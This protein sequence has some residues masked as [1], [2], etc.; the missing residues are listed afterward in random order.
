MA[1]KFQFG[2]AVM[3]GSLDQE[4]A[5]DIIG[6]EAD[7]AELKLGGT[8]VVDSNRDVFGRIL[9]ASSEIRIG[10][11]QITQAE[12]ETIDGVTA[13]TVAASKAVVVDSD[14]DVSGFR[15]VTGTGNITAGGSFIIGLIYVSERLIGESVFR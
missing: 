9:S 11:A 15:N 12:L 3:S 8:T 13:G 1:Y 4:G 2:P 7:S 10:A 14:K 6:N 5:L